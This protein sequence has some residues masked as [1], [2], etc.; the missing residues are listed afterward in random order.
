MAFVPALLA[1]LPLAAASQTEPKF[2]RATE[3]VAGSYI[4]VLDPRP[5]NASGLLPPLAASLMRRYGGRATHHY[6]VALQ[7][8]AAEM[9][10]AQA[11]LLSAD[12]QVAWIEE[13]STGHVHGVQSVPTLP[14]LDR[15]DVTLGPN[16]SLYHY[17]LSGAGTHIYIIDTGIRI[18]NV[19]F[20]GRAIG[21]YNT[22]PDGNGTNDCFGH[23]TV[24][25]SAAAG[26]TYGVAKGATIHAIRTGDCN[27]RFDLART[28]DAINWVAAHHIG[29]AVANMS[30]G[31][32]GA[33]ASFDTA[34]QNLI[35]AG[36]VVTASAGN[37]FGGDSCLNSPARVGPA[38]TVGATTGS[39]YATVAGFSSQGSCVDMFAPGDGI[40][41]ASNSSDTGTVTSSGTSVAAPLVAGAAAMYLAGHPT[42]TTTNTV[43]AVIGGAT[44]FIV[45]GVNTGAGNRML[46]TGFVTCATNTVCS[47]VCVNTQTDANNC[48]SCGQVCETFVNNYCVN[49]GC[50][51][52]PSGYTTCC[53]GDVCKPPGQKCPAQCP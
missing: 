1:L 22:I 11:L 40:M 9:T 51:A 49:G 24:V 31:F 29:P 46:Y 32:T 43:N 8:F 52:C 14:D 15:L 35:S 19:D 12:P 13:D 21:S 37:D 50:S 33:T 27:G 5:A 18:T 28:I 6:E 26:A 53:S 47:D 34:V 45:L 23:G 41:T 4:V 44:P 25:A 7:G 30:F 38:I 2:R 10:E 39:D 36:V 42:S 16:D 17:L 3:R 48:G 20:G